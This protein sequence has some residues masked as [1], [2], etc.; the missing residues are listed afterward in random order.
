MDANEGGFSPEG[1][2]LDE[3]LLPYRLQRAIGIFAIA[4]CLLGFCSLSDLGIHSPLL[5]LLRKEWTKGR[6]REITARGTRTSCVR[7]ALRAIATAGSG[8]WTPPGS[9][10]LSS[11][12]GRASH[13][14][15][16]CQVSLLLVALNV[17]FFFLVC[18]AEYS[19]VCYLLSFASRS[20]GGT[21]ATLASLAAV[22][23]A[24]NWVLLP[25][26]WC[27]EGGN[28]TGTA[29]TSSSRV[30]NWLPPNCVEEAEMLEI[31]SVAERCLARKQRTL[32]LFKQL[33]QVMDFLYGP[34]APYLSLYE[35]TLR[36][37]LVHSHAVR[38]LG[39]QLL[40][41]EGSWV[42]EHC[43]E[44]NPAYQAYQLHSIL[45]GAP[46]QIVEEWRSPLLLSASEPM[47]GIDG[48]G[49]FGSA[50]RHDHR[51]AQLRYV[52]YVPLGNSRAKSM[53]RWQPEALAQWAQQLTSTSFPDIEAWNLDVHM[54]AQVLENTFVDQININ[55]PKQGRIKRK[56]H[57][58]D[59][60]AGRAS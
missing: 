31:G 19:I 10:L 40:K 13:L 33:N 17:A 47:D 20:S 9:V 39:L 48:G 7:A 58:S 44:H 35:R 24:G 52:D 26:Q 2:E 41:C 50:E 27:C 55:V 56:T 60:I 51:V 14:K 15:V 3:S 4:I 30:S 12:A 49:Y 34:L 23:R 45:A 8:F 46:V 43:S 22:G 38:A 1:E 25:F 59:A 16:G 42:N 21:A 36:S 57:L 5:G 29:A 53:K 6:R 11:Y 32:L 18:T 37:I 54:H 28:F